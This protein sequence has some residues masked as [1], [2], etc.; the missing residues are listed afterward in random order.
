LVP[1]QLKV[2][3]QAEV[4]VYAL[5]QAQEFVAVVV[6]KVIFPASFC[7]AVLIPAKLDAVT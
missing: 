1:E 2:V 7:A 6:A 3:V 4:V 5:E